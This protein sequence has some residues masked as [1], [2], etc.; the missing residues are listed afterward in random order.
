[1]CVFFD[2]NV[3]LDVF[4]ERE[5][6][7]SESM[8]AWTLAESGRISGFIS[9]ISYNNC[10]YIVRKYGNS[11]KAYKA[12]RLMRDIFRPI[13]LSTQILNQAMDAGFSD[14]EDAIQYFSALHSEVE[15]LL[16]RI[17]DHFPKSDISILSP[18]EFLALHFS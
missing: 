4:A 14:F 9:A 11:R 12:V 6:F 2:T 17:P 1:M 15:V 7:Y 18:A 13:D 16:T 5:P 8:R 3:L 10:F